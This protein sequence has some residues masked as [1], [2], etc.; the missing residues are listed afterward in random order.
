M[1]TVCRLFG[2]GLLLGVLL[3]TGC[4][5]SQKADEYDAYLFSYFTGN[6]PGEESIHYAL[7]QDGYNFKAL[8]GN[9]PILDSKVISTS[10]GVR[11]PHILRGEDGNFYMVVT[12]LYV[13][14]MG[15]Q[16]YAMVLLKSKDLIHWTHSVVNIPESFEEYADV[17]RVWAPQTIYDEVTGKYM[18]YFSMLQPEGYDIIYYAYANEDFTG[19][20][21]SPKQLLFNP[22]E[23][24]T[25]DGDIIKKDGKYHLFFKTEGGEKG[26]AKAISNSLTH[27]YEVLPG[28]VDLTDYQVEG[29]GIFKLNDSDDYILMYDMYNVGKYQFTKSSDL[30]HFEIIDEAV[31]M[32][33]HPRHG[34]VL[35][36]T[37]KEA[38]RLLNK[39][40]FD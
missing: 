1:N 37:K 36:I 12:D 16:N 29:S 25:I 13:P 24:A 9:Q 6:G 21:S 19:L 17:Y 7:S 5:E 2:T 8:N 27:G 10:G 20:A 34:T 32:D 38:D 14:E 15:W 31:T 30:Q 28:H 40:P 11:D 39:W 33:F 26:I 35:P 3:L 18:I 23:F 22:G 4:S